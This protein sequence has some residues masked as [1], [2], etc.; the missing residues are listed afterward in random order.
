M[1]RTVAQIWLQ[2]CWRCRTV[3][4]SCGRH[5]CRVAVDTAELLAASCV[6]VGRLRVVGVKLRS[7]SA[8]PKKHIIMLLRG[9]CTVVSSSCW[10]VLF[11]CSQN[12]WEGAM[13]QNKSLRDGF[14]CLFH[15]LNTFLVSL[16][17]FFSLFGQGAG[18]EGAFPCLF[19]LRQCMCALTSLLLRLAI[20][21]HFLCLSGFF[22]GAFFRFAWEAAG[23]GPP[24]RFPPFV[25]PFFY[26]KFS[27]LMPLPRFVL[28]II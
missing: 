22:Q 16:L 14:L 12:L 15:L 13:F 6:W 28:C 10:L 18:W 27:S 24:S 20:K 26:S 3:C 19:S 17:F 9:V 25:P 7:Q 23:N 5:N 4:S 1:S 21:K 8:L 11:Q 2:T